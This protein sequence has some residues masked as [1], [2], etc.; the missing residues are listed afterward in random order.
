MRSRYRTRSFLDTR[1]SPSMSTS[2]KATVSKKVDVWPDH[3]MR[4]HMNNRKC[5]K[6]DTE[7]GGNIEPWDLCG[8]P[9]R[10]TKSA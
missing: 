6:F 5:H 2:V 9:S 3:S 8:S 7:T 1:P 10:I 4:S